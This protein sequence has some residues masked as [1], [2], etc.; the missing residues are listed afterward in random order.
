MAANWNNPTLTSLYTVVLDEL[1]NRDKDLAKWFD[2]GDSA[3]PT[4]LETGYK[5]WNSSNRYWEE[6]NGT[7]WVALSTKYNISVDGTASNVTGTVTIANGGTGA[8][9]AAGARTN[10]GIPSVIDNLTSTSTTSALSA[11]QGTTLKSI[12]DNCWKKTENILG[13]TY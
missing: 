1:K 12:T 8:T 6:Y 5:R 10:L 4:V 13:G 3:T 7:T 11:N 2:A 9:T